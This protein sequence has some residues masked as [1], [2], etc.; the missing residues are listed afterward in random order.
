MEVPQAGPEYLFFCFGCAVVPFICS[1]FRCG[2][3]YHL[4]VRLR[5]SDLSCFFFLCVCVCLCLGLLGFQGVVLC[6]KG[7]S[8]PTGD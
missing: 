6:I 7:V 5:L 8:Q 4:G 1:F 3:L 2:F